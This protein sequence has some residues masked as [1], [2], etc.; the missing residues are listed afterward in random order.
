VR[1]II[2]ITLEQ[3]VEVHMRTVEVSGG[4]AHGLLDEGPLLGTLEQIQNDD[5]YP[6]IESKL[7]HLVY[8]T[9]RNH[10]FRDGNKRIAIALGAQFLLL[11]GYVFLV[12][13]FLV[14]ME[15]ISY[16]LAAG[17][18]SKDLLRKIVEALL[19]GEEEDEE[20]KLEILHAISKDLSTNGFDPPS[21][22]PPLQ[23]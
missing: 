17:L 20:L 6:D 13:R 15:N 21:E 14:Y 1:A 22:N 23:S 8:A 5:W 10:C 16:H 11:N 7:T 18:I 9:N 3:A 2:Y 19:S 12:P 4:G